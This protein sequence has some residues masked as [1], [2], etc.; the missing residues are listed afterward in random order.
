MRAA[1][2]NGSNVVVRVVLLDSLEQL[3]GAID[4]TGA[5]VGDTW[6]GS[7]FVKPSPSVVPPSEVTMRQA[8]RAL[9]AAGLLDD[10]EAAINAMSEPARTAARIDWDYSSTVKRDNATLAAL[11]AAL[12]LSG[13]QLDELFVAAAGIE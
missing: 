8:R 6:N 7:T 1:I 11:A 2:L 4:G 10:V 9:L 13:A 3:P 5:D 12:G